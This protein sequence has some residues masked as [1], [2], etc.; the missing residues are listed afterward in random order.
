MDVTLHN[1]YF[2]F[3]GINCE[4]SY[5]FSQRS[6]IQDAR[7]QTYADP[8]QRSSHVLRLSDTFN[9]LALWVTYT[10]VSPE[11]TKG[12]IDAVTRVIGL[13]EILMKM[14]NM[15]GVFAVMAGIGHPCVQRMTRTLSKLG[16]RADKRL[17]DFQRLTSSRNS[18]KNYKAYLAQLSSG[19]KPFI[20]FVAL[21]LTAIAD[22][23]VDVIDIDGNETQQINMDNHYMMATLFDDLRHMQSMARFYRFPRMNSIDETTMA[24]MLR[25]PFQLVSTLDG[26]NSLFE[27]M[28]QR[29]EP[30]V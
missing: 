16:T 29:N 24:T 19:K 8:S 17:R 18:F 5:A 15:N 4:M 20:P 3:T 9:E 14:D 1:V 7:W 6:E 23:N 2:M 28:S 11:H 21:L 26:L 27:S 10:I 22:A 13:A 25:S 12:R 30:G